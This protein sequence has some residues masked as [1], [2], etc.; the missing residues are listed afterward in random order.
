MSTPDT[1]ILDLNKSIRAL[2]KRITRENGDGDGYVNHIL[3]DVVQ[4]L[5]Q[6]TSAM[7]SLMTYAEAER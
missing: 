3:E 5:S 2:H 7:S 1:I 4:C 6:E